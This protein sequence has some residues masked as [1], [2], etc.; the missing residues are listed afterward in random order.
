MSGKRNKTR[1]R[2]SVCHRLPFFVAGFWP[3]DRLLIVSLIIFRDMPCMRRLTGTNRRR[4][5]GQQ[6][7]TKSGIRAADAPQVVNFLVRL[8]RTC[9]ARKGFTETDR[10]RSIGQ[11]RG[12]GCLL[13][14]PT[15]WLAVLP[16]HAL[17]RRPAVRRPAPTRPWSVWVL[18]STGT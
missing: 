2:Q 1:A 11:Q 10:C 17:P 5:T 7:G 8:S 12:V 6:P 13:G 9:L 3:L 14:E 18:Y 15:R 4:F 16:R